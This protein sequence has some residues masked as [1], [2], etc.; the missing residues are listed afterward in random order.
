ML[1]GLR[2]YVAILVPLA[3]FFDLDQGTGHLVWDIVVDLLF[4]ADIGLNFRTGF[5]DKAKVLVTDKLKVP[6]ELPKGDYVLSWRWDC[7]Q[8]P[9][10]WNGC[11][12][13]TVE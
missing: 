9:Q 10:V 4:I 5:V 1:C 7:E 2:Q 13:V 11:A 8:T 3:T 6:A 12:D